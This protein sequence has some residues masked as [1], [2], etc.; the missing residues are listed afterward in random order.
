MITM[1]ITRPLVSQSPQSHPSFWDI[2]LL[3]TWLKCR[4][5]LNSDRSPRLLTKISVLPDLLDL[6][7]KKITVP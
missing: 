3:R 4:D 5:L 7:L 1:S 2:L 6:T